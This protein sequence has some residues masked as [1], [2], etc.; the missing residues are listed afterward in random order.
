MQIN[1]RLKNYRNYLEN[2]NIE[3][4]FILN[5]DLQFYLSGFKALMYSRPIVLYIDKK[6]SSIVVP[7]LEEFHANEEADVD[8]VYAYYEHPNPRGEEL[9]HF[10]FIK[11]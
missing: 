6:K 2:N 10:E 11:G 8:E 7:G 1:E 5:P 3:G 4:T 9:N